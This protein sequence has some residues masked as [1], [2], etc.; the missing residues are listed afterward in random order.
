VAG[1]G[2]I[3]AGRYTRNLDAIDNY[4]H[5]VLFALD[6][7]AYDNSGVEVAG[8][9]VQ[10][11][12][13]ITVHPWA[14]TY[15]GQLRL[16]DSDTYVSLGFAQ[17]IPG[18]NDGTQAAFCATRVNASGDCAP[19]RYQIWQ[20]GFSHSQ[21]LPG[22]WQLRLA[23]NGQWTRDQLI[24]GEQFGIGGMDSVRGFY[25]REVTGDKGYRGT[26]ELY[27]PDL[28]ALLG[29]AG[30]RLRALTFYDWGGVKRIDP[31]PGEPGRQTI[32]S[33]GLG[34]RLAYERSLILRT[35]WGYVLNGGGQQGAG[36]SLVQFRV[37]YIF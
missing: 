24:P 18:G 8:T 13:D 10:L 17:N 1:A 23:M 19:A 26:T 12:P 15:Q 35:D 7:R 30:L 11:I 28:G 32:A 9:G 21:V 20:P 27:S 6:Y 36:D 29:V 25:E 14:V 2:T 22:D 16:P 37:S 31:L 33:T 4:E 3:F 34:V 5:R